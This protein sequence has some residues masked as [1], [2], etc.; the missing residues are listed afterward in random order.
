MKCKGCGV[1]GFK[2]DE[3]VDYRGD[4]KLLC[5]ECADMED[6]KDKHDF[7]DEEDQSSDDED[8]EEDVPD[9]QK[10]WPPDGK[11]WYR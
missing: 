5:G 2:R 1:T 10:E 6:I 7:E 8:D 3:L 11:C 9:S 4:G